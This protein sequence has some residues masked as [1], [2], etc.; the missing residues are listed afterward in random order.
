MKPH[1]KWTSEEIALETM[2]RNLAYGKTAPD[3]PIRWAFVLPIVAIIS[4]AVWA[5]FIHAAVNALAPCG[6]C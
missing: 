5:F 4:V 1:N 3:K 2:R 6:M